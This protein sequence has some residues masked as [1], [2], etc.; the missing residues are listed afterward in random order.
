MSHGFP[1]QAFGSRINN[2]AQDNAWAESGAIY[3]SR[4]VLNLTDSLEPGFLKRY[5]LL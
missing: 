5:R 1:P 3:G 4:W 2:K